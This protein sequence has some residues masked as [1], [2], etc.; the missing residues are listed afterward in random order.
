M[1]GLELGHDACYLRDNDTEPNW[2]QHHGLT[3]AGF[4]SWMLKGK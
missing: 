4:T 1:L 2:I 3:A